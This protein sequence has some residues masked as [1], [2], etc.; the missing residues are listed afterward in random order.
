MRSCCQ[1]PA[2]GR[3]GELTPDTCLDLKDGK[4]DDGMPLQ[5]WTCAEGELIQ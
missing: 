4:T 3:E 1:E 5:Q 2:V